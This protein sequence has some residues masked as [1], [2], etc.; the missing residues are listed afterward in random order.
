MPHFK[1]AMKHHG[2]AGK[3]LKANDHST[4]MQHVGHMMAALRANG[5]E[6]GEQGNNAGNVGTPDDARMGDTAM[7]ATPAPDTKKAGPFDPMAGL[8]KRLSLFGR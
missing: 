6:M 2:L 8:R 3:A 5:P 1:R 4:A 7:D